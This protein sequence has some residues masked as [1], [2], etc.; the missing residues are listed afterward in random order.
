MEILIRE[1]LQRKKLSGRAGRRAWGFEKRLE[2]GKGSVLARRWKKMREEVW[3]G[4]EDSEWKKER[5]VF[6]E[7]R[8]MQ[9]EE[10]ERGRRSGREGEGWFGELESPYPILIERFRERRDGRK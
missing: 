8:G 1:E 5:K 6:F 10:V 9:I 7:D 3:T 2:K 4:R